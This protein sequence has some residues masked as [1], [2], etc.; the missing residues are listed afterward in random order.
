MV[1]VFLVL[2]M[3]AAA[4]QESESLD[5]DIDTIFDEPLPGSV[6][7]ADA[8]DDAGGITVSRLIKQRG[9]AFDASYEFFAGVSPGWNEAPWTPNFADRVFT[10]A[11]GAKMKG[12]LGLD[13]QISE[14]FRV[15]NN[16]S[17]QI[18]NFSFALGDFFFDYNF[19]DAV[20]VRGG[21]Y[22]LSWGISPNYQFT[23]LLA[24]V[25]PGRPAGESF[26]LKADIPIGIG[27]IQF[28]ALTRANLMGGVLPDVKQDIA[29]GGKYNLALRW[30]DIDI[31]T[32]F[33]PG[34]PLRNFLSI[35]TT[36]GKTELYNEWTVSFFIKQPETASGAGNIGFARD[37][38]GGKLTVN[39]ELFFNVE[40]NAWWYVPETD[41]N[42]AR[43]SLFIN[44]LN[45]ALN[46]I[47]RL[48]GKG[49][50]R[51]F[52]QL[53]YAPMEYSAQFVPGFR[54]KPWPH[55]EFYFALPMAFG[56]R[57]GYYYTHTFIYDNQN[58]PRPFSF[59][60]LLSLTG[61]LQYGYYF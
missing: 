33:Q 50:P 12:S 45:G 43:S 39:G 41:L 25:A 56:N 10:V 16:I 60:F 2:L 24:R 52:S 6:S 9:F 30:A 21:K 55:I 61:G 17:F 27:G 15:R 22:G 57:D 34:M 5:W 54:I 59:L 19:Y 14:A 42:A 35:K 44:G 1:C 13:V 32:F 53:L 8:S 38:L 37:L 3:T 11:P 29:L 26:I 58:R 23:N 48:D 31:G 40:E 28:L 51:L 46:L 36:V 47:Y 20:F 49:E 18:P 4:A 7:G